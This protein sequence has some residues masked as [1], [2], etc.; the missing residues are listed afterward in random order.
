MAKKKKTKKKAAAGG[1]PD[2][3]VKS[4][5]KEALKAHDVNVASDALDGLNG[6]VAW[7]IEQ[8]AKRAAANGRKTVRAHD[9]VA[10]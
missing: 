3:V 4:K 7:Y 8:A 1:A 10:M 6:V 9:F 5:C 2:L